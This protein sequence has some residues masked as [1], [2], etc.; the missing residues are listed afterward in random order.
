M[1]PHERDHM[2]DTK[3]YIGCLPCLLNDYPNMHADYHHLAPGR[4][5]LG[6]E[7]GFGMCLWHHRG[8]RDWTWGHVPMG[9]MRSRLGPSLAREKRVFI[10]TYG[11]EMLLMELNN[12]ALSLWHAEPW[13]E[14]LMPA[15]VMHTVQ[16]HHRGLCG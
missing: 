13:L 10:E 2:R 14:H 8:E 11:S 12:F 6:H 15:A 5:R 4:K 16:R 7:Y 9:E 1:K 3:L